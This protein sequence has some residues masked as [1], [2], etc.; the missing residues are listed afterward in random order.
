MLILPVLSFA[1]QGVFLDFVNNT[2]ET[3]NLYLV[4]DQGVTSI[5]P[6]LIILSPSANGQPQEIYVQGEMGM[7]WGV[8]GSIDYQIINTKNQVLG[9]ATY[10]GSRKTDY[11][12]N[13][14][15]YT[16][17]QEIL[18][19]TAYMGSTQCVNTNQ[20]LHWAHSYFYITANSNNKA[21]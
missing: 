21:K 5:L 4:S 11:K 2:N 7:D 3:L 19:N 1:Y 14:C 12:E 9:N 20:K 8:D 18:T 16:S 13:P 6:E 17:L 15:E 10:T